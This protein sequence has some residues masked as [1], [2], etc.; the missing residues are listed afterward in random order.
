VIDDYVYDV[1]SW[2]KKHPGGSILLGHFAG[3]D[4]TVSVALWVKFSALIL[5]VHN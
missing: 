1:T 4:A 2:S 3:Q 5:A